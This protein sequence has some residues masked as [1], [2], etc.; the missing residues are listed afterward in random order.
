MW[1]FFTYLGSRGSGWPVPLSAPDVAAGFAR[2]IQTATKLQSSNPSVQVFKESEFNRNLVYFITRSD[3]GPKP[4]ASMASYSAAGC[5][6]DSI[7]K[8]V[9][10]LLPLY[11]YVTL[12]DACAHIWDLGLR[13]CQS[14]CLHRQFDPALLEASKRQPS[15]NRPPQ[16]SQF[17]TKA[18]S[19]M[20]RCL[21][22]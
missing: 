8:G 11:P 13:G 17:S 15:C 19:I 10:D 20:Q 18:S 21:P 3:A 7:D 2:C 6:D 12:R 1:C 22:P 9:C 4:F 14:L 16:G 5:R